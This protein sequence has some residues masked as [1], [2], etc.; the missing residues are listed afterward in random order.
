[1]AWPLSCLLGVFKKGGIPLQTVLH[2]ESCWVSPLPPG[3]PLFPAA[4][5]WGLTSEGRAGGEVVELW[6]RRGEPKVGRVGERWPGGRAA[7]SLGRVGGCR[8]INT[9]QVTGP[10]NEG[11]E[12]VTFRGAWERGQGA[13]T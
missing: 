8:A 9:S 1:M 6:Q 13:M 10:V 3:L 12:L 5:A 4:A 2:S 11:R 7:E